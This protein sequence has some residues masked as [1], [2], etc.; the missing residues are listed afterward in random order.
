MPNPSTDT[1]SL[2]A[3]ILEG[4]DT[5]T[6]NLAVALPG[7]VISYDEGSQTAIIQPGVNRAVPSLDDAE[8]DEFE[9]LP[10]IEGVP[11][12]WLIGRGIRVNASL[13]PGDPVLII[14]MD[15]DPSGWLGM[16]GEI[17]DPDDTRTHHWSHAV[18]IPGLVPE[19]SPFPEPSDAAALASKVDLLIGILRNH[20]LVGSGSVNLVADAV[21]TAFP[22]IPL[23]AAIDP[24]DTTGSR[25]LLLTD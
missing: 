2:A 4:I 6:R 8:V 1:P 11:V 9:E 20:S 14:A 10:A 19:T 13:E 22:N 25:V 21:G 12:C 18:A 15:R 5:A 3:V 7:T 16:G 23:Q 24:A 17:S